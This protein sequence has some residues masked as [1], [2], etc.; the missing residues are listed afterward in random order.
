M[1]KVHSSVWAQAIEKGASRGAPRSLVRTGPVPDS[2]LV[3]RV[4]ECFVLD[5]PFTE[6][7]ESCAHVAILARMTA[8]RGAVH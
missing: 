1:K 4:A 3:T 8:A 6:S 7:K 5:G 2:N